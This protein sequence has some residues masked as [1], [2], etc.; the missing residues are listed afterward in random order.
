MNRVHFNPA[1][2]SRLLP[3]VENLRHEADE[4]IHEHDDTRAY[5]L[6]A[7]EGE[8]IFALS[9]DKDSPS[10]TLT[11]CKSQLLLRL[12]LEGRSLTLEQQRLRGWI[13]GMLESIAFALEGSEQ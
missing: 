8:L 1:A 11:R 12:G 3:A 13:V 10:G 2:G 6:G 5:L 4:L 9:V 7:L